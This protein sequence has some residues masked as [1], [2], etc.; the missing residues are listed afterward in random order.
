[1][2]KYHGYNRPTT[3]DSDSGSDPVPH[4]HVFLV[5]VSLALQQRSLYRSRDVRRDPCGLQWCA[6]CC[7]VVGEHAELC[8]FVNISTPVC[9][10]LNPAPCLVWPPLHQ[11]AFGGPALPRPAG[12]AYS[13][14]PDP[15]WIWGG[16]DGKARIGRGRDGETGRVGEGKGRGRGGMRPGMG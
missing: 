3:A 11:N 10:A 1:M 15:S 8:D 9:K 16:D 6:E 14:P 12:G 2:N 7:P 5:S 4:P 13:A